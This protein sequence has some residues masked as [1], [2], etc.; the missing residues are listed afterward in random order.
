MIFTI[1]LSLILATAVYIFLLQPKF[2]SVPSGDRLERIEKSPNYR[3]GSFQ[4]LSPTPDLTEGSNYVSIMWEFL[5]SRKER[6]KPETAMPSKRT[7]ILALDPAENVLIWFGHS[8]YFM[9][10][11]GKKILVDPVFSGSASPLPLGTRAFEGT[12]IYTADDFP[13]IDYLFITHD[14]WDHVDYATLMAL[15]PK[16]K[17]IITGLGTGAHLE[18]W[19]FDPALIIEKDWNESI[20]LDPGFTA[21]TT[22]ARHFSGRGIRRNKALWTA[23]VLTTPN[24]QIYIGGD[25]GYDTHFAEIGNKFGPFDLAI[26]E[27]GQYDKSWKYIHM[28]PDEVLMAGQDLGAKSILPV[29]SGK[30]SLANHA[31]DTPLD[32]ITE[33]NVDVG[34][35]LITPM[36]GEK[37]NINDSTQ[38]FSQWWKGMP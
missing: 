20:Q 34:L 6:M 32:K 18:S 2:G 24:L 5:F 25:S 38:T 11:D 36:I 31:W 7:D 28:M 33:L 16:I 1:T 22:P 30:F 17:K 19:E 26:L 35:R 27:N 21:F 14:H 12:D 23:F 9:Q 15:K 10:V 29:H 4:N 13:V 3:D 8:S 37:V